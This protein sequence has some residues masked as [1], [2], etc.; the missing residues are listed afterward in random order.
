MKEDIKN[1]KIQAV[2]VWKLDRLARNTK[3]LLGLIDFFNQYNII[4][5][6][7]NESIETATASGKFFLTVL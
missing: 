1:G 6:S 2:I 7:A 4:F 3:V 5:I